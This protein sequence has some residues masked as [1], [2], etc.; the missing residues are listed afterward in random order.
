MKQ[1]TIISK[2]TTKKGNKLV[3][4]TVSLNDLDA[5]LSYANRL[6][7]EDTFVMLSGKPL[8][9]KEERK[10]LKEA[11]ALM[12]SGKKIHIVSEVNGRFAGSCEV[13]MFD[14]RKVHVGEIGISIS[15]E[16]R[17]EG[18][19]RQCM[20][21]L[22]GLARQAGLKLLYLHCFENN[23][24]A[25]GLYGSVGFKKSGTV[26]GMYAWRNKY[27]GEVTLYLPLN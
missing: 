16:F 6:V 12:E 19:G 7:A 3:I 22:I 23:R 26:P 25:L 4:R 27:I 20:L 5:L 21:T 10:Y 8:T 24:A 14:R 15:E 11:V 17:G 9:E 2:S 13:R 18:I 1:G